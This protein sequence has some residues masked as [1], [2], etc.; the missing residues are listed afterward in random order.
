MEAKLNRKELLQ[1]A[2]SGE[3]ASFSLYSQAAVLATSE[4][5]K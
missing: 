2:A 3:K 5:V 4:R 1:L